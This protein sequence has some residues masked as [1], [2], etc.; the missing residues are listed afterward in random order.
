MSIGSR[1]VVVLRSQV[2]VLAMLLA[3]S[4]E[5]LPVY[6][7]TP[8][9]EPSVKPPGYAPR[10]LGTTYLA[11]GDSLVT[12]TEETGN[13]DNLPGYPD[14]LFSYL[15]TIKP[16]LGLVKLGRDGETST[17][18]ITTTSTITGNQLDIAVNFIKSERAAGRRVGLVTLDIGG[19]DLIDVLLNNSLD[20]NI[21]LAK[22]RQNLS[23][24]LDRLLD[25]LTVNNV[26]DGDLL[27][28]DY[29]NP[30][31]GLKQKFPTIVD[32]DVYVPVL[33]GII[34]EAA[35]TRGLPVTE[36]FSAFAGKEAEYIYVQR[37]YA[38]F[39]VP[40][41]YDYHPRPAGHRAIASSFLSVSGYRVS[42][43]VTT[44]IKS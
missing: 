8:T 17:T 28:M 36:V 6:A 34:K 1:P 26:R 9:P 29:Y 41:A 5:L 33:N 40:K 21:V 42:V 22:Y 27:L 24:I 44:V 13:N 20:P 15:R 43:Y 11:L 30:Y 10:G 25:A 2:I 23:T 4:S 12:G 16:D 31:P 3:L 7:D 14:I 38:D 32:P 18:M 35:A 19:N 39:P 37:P